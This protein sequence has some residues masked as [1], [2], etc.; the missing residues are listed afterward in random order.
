[1][2]FRIFSIQ[3]NRETKTIREAIQLAIRINTEY[4]EQDRAAASGSEQEMKPWLE[5][6]FNLPAHLRSFI[7]LAFLAK[8][9]PNAGFRVSIDAVHNLPKPALIKVV[10]CLSPPAP[11]YQ[12]PIMTEDV[13]FTV[14]HDW[15]ISAVSPHFTDGYHVYSPF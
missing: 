2:D 3:A 1:M 4:E 13:D 12:D 9:Q 6:R 14:G 15:D 7:D 5:D 10:Y 11:Y 8:Y